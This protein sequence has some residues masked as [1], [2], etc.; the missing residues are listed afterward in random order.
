MTAEWI[1]S[2]TVAGAL[3]MYFVAIMAHREPM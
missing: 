2:L 1:L 3:Q